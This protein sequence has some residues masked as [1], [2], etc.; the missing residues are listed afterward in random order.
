MSWHALSGGLLRA[1]THLDLGCEFRG[2]QRQVLYLAAEQGRAGR[3]VRVAAP[4]GAPILER[5]AAQGLSTLSLPARRDFDPRN[6][7]V[8]ARALDASEI[9]H[10]HDARAASLGALVRLV[11]PGT[12]LMHTRR[13]S[14]P[15]GRGWSA[16]KYRLADVVACVSRE[17]EEAVR[18]AGV[19]RTVVIPSA[20]VLDRYS[21]RLSGNGGR[22]GIIGALSPQKGHSRLFEALSLMDRVPE[23]W[24]VGSGNLEAELRAQCARLGIADRV[25]WKGEVESPQVLPLFDA[26]VVPSAHGEGSSGV[27]KEAWA[28]GV[29]VVCSDLPANLELVRDGE[30][31][32]TF[33]N[34]DAA[35]LA[36]QLERLR[37]DQ[38]LA[39]RLAAGGAEDVLACDASFMAEAY[40]RA[41]ERL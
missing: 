14:Y 22:L 38:A 40:A 5:A 11:R 13:V 41:Y 33:P 6:L 35:A 27:V 29:P 1:V 28:A 25:V 2:G 24:V 7:F 9:L 39:G 16:L 3:R 15:L 10:T 26:L 31:G 21:R 8:L 37:D 12:S 36:W 4:A 32:L 17:V 23:V 34:G 19:T 18:L 20:I 30:N